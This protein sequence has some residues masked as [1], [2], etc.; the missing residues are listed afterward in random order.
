MFSL[1][2]QGLGGGIA[3]GRARVLAMQ[4]RDVPR[5]HIDA[6]RVS[7]EIARLTEA[8]DSARAAFEAVSDR[9]PANAPQEARALLDVH[10]M[11][12]AD[13]MLVDS[14][15]D[16]IRDDL[17]NA[18]W[19]IA[20]QAEALANQFQQL[21]DPYLRERDRD[22]RQVADRI[23]KALVGTSRLIGGH[24]EEPLIFVADDLAPADILELKHG[25]GFAIDLGGTTSHTAILA[26]S[27][28]VPAAVGMHCASD[29]VRDDDWVILDGDAG[30]VVVA[31]D[32]A[33]LAEYRHRQA[34]RELERSRLKRLVNIP[35][36][37]LDGV[38]VTLMANIEMPDEAAIALDNGAHGVGLFRTEFLF[39][40]RT[41]TPTEDEQYEAYRAVAI[42]MEGRVVTIRTL[43]VGADKSLEQDAYDHHA[44]NPALGR[45]AVRYCLTRP[46]MFLTQLRAIL[47]AS[48]HGPIRLLLPMITH[49]REIVECLRLIERAR[50]QLVTRHQAMAADVP[51]GAMIEVPA[52]ALSAGFFVRHLDFLSIGTNDLIQYTLAI[53]RADHEVASLYDSF[54]PAVLRLI[55]QTIDAA[56]K[57]GKPV[58]IC[59]E[60]AGD[61][62]ATRL[63]LGMGLVE[64]SMHPV[65]LLKVKREV[66]LA[67]VKRL[68]A[69]VSRLVRI[70]DPARVASALQ[71]L[72]LPEAGG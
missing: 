42:A 25:I 35:S 21:D 3:I 56:R 31:P 38:E 54:H 19:A 15:L 6:Q 71:K 23:L 55:A 62:I 51:V 47:R 59:G 12:L 72:A 41:E 45:R 36:R 64:F 2:G 61:P 52:A 8:T 40:N 28:D 66:L 39:M 17:R 20:A 53:D 69:P 44:L 63:L 32:D 50:D 29:M 26:R 22:V 24:S 65:S 37:T 4:V 14:A 33:V 10:L 1:H 18:E 11:I 70:D 16:W 48:A 57:A 60:L 13:P 27:M 46:D 58:S 43:D 7:R 49:Y 9:L 30:L 68:S 5:Y 34:S 67:E